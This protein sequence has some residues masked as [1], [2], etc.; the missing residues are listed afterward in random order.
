MILDTN[1]LSAFFDG[2]EA[3]VSRV[4]G[5]EAVYLLVIVIGEYRFGLRGLRLRRER[6]PKFL[7]ATKLLQPGQK[8]KLTFTAPGLP[9]M[10]G[11]VCT[12][13]GHWLTMR[14]TLEVIEPEAP[15]K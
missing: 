11:Y 4:A 7:W 12:F 6:E 8:E 1:G 2:E 14:G 13:P 10:R 15:V 3:V 5:A 9:G